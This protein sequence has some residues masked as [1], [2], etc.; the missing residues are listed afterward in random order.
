MFNSPITLQSSPLPTPSEAAGGWDLAPP[1]A[2]RFLHLDWSHTA[3]DYT[4]KWV[5]GMISG[6]PAPKVK[7]LP[8]NWRDRMVDARGMIAS[9]IKTRP[10][11][12]FMMPENE[13]RAGREW[14][15]PRSWDMASRLLAAAQAYGASKDTLVELLDGCVG[16]S[17]GVEFLTWYENLDLPDPEEILRNPETFKLLSVA[18]RLSRY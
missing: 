17:E 18:I 5:E 12:L 7:R 6:F 14:A 4:N 10:N 1:L 3:N 11:K 9:Y 13:T 15:S 2:N 8:E 16:P